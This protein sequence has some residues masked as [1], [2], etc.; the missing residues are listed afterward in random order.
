MITNNL[1]QW[2]WLLAGLLICGLA[3]WLAA[4]APTAASPAAVAERP[5]TLYLVPWAEQD[6]QQ[7]MP[8]NNDTLA[9]QPDAPR[10]DPGILSADGATQITMAHPDGRSVYSPGLNPDEI[11]IVVSDAPGGAERGRFHPPAQ[12]L[13]SSVSADGA[14]LLLQADA[15]PQ[16]QVPYPPRMDWY[17]LDTDDGAVISHLADPDTACHRQRTIADAAL[18]RIYCVMDP[19]LSDPE[20]PGPLRLAAYDVASGAQAGMLT[21]PDV[22]IGQEVHDEQAKNGQMAIT[23]L[24]PALTLSPDGRQLAIVHAGADAV[25]LVNASDL[26][27][28]TTFSLDDGG[29]GWDGFGLA[30]TPVHA[31]AEIAG[32]IRQAAYSADGQ[33]LIV[34]T[35]Q[36]WIDP[37]DAPDARGL[38]LVDLAQEEIVTAALPAYQIQWM[39]PAPDGAIYA[40][41]TTEADLGPYEIRET[42]PSMLWRLDGRSLAVLA[43]RPF[44]GYRGGRLLLNQP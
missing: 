23:L 26:T 24:E 19:A 35:Q 6:D 33:T 1:R 21:L 32:V 43:E 34:F 8:L 29:G 13:I 3:G 2:R 41:G 11:W 16:G 4:C 5:Y 22:S 30:A 20:S 9:S 14:R 10:L 44:S 27:I 42:S 28:E 25:T 17:V 15:F 12:G 31:K 7:F 40:F 37:A 18:R 39:L 38:W 36:L